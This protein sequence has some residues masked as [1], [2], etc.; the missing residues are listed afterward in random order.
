MA[1]LAG[2]RQFLQLSDASFVVVNACA[3]DVRRVAYHQRIADFAGPLFLAW[4]WPPILAPYAGG[5]LS[6][7]TKF[8]EEFRPLST[9]QFGVVL[10]HK[11]GPKGVGRYGSF[12]AVK[13]E[14]VGVF[15]NPGAFFLVELCQAA[16]A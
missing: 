8:W 12:G 13:N 1:L 9:L 4:F 5:A 6:R 7:L 10:P 16:I 2:A 14:N 3:D 15:P 11:I